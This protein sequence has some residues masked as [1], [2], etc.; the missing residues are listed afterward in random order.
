VPLD[1]IPGEETR[2]VWDP[3]AQTLEYAQ[4]LAR[5]IRAAGGIVVGCS[6][7]E[8]VKRGRACPVCGGRGLA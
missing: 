5:R 8:Q 2:I 4:A 1:T 6:L 3:R 7:D